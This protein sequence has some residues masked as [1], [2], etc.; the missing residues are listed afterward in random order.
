[1]SYYEF[2]SDSGTGYGSLDVFWWGDLF[3]SVEPRL[4]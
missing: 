1:M 2:A 4:G 3:P